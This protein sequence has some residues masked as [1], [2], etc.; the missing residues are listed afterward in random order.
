MY[1]YVLEVGGCVQ[2]GNRFV[3]FVRA[4]GRG[5]AKLRGRARGDQIPVLGASWT[6]CGVRVRVP[7]PPGS[8]CPVVRLSRFLRFSTF[9]VCSPAVL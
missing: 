4:S 1:V 2:P 8:G 7:R 5:E 6:S 9:A 3:S